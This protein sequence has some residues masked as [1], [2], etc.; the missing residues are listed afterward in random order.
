MHFLPEEIENYAKEYTEPENEVLHE[1]NRQT[2]LKALKPRMLSGHLQGR[3][4][5]MF[6]HMIAPKN[7]LEIGT[8]TGYSAICLAE[9]LQKQGKVHTIDN[10]D[11]LEDMIEE[12]I[13]NANMQDKIEFHNGNALDIINQ[14]NKTFDI[15]FIDADKENYS[16]Y[17][18]AVIDKV[19]S[20]GIIIADNVLW[21]GKVLKPNDE[22]DKDSIAIK[23]FN[24][25]V[26]EDERVENVLLPIR[27]GLMVVRKVEIL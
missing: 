2:Q 20:G 15:V 23:S 12:A 5:S 24:K 1:L 18:D 8:Y 4:L 9:G 27:D 16:N 13:T 10:N 21:N 17:F 26:H 14:M 19:Q 7:V 22:L 11:E 6:S 3:V 25:K